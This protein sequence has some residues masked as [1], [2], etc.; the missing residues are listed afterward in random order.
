MRGERREWRSRG[1]EGLPRGA[2]LGRKRIGGKGTSWE[3]INV[4]EGK[5]QQR[6]ESRC[7]MLGCCKLKRGM[8]DVGGWGGRYEGIECSHDQKR[9]S[10]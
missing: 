7:G 9:K 8:K 3:S 6:R 4:K 2:R 10:D 5:K 1:G